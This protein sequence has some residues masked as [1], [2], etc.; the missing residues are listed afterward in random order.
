MARR[1]P[2]ARSRE[3]QHFRVRVFMEG[4]EISEGIRELGMAKGITAA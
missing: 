3:K 4:S 2:P 1:R